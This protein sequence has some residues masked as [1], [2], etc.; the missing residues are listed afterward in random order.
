MTGWDTFF[1]VMALLDVVFVGAL[2]FVGLKMLDSVK[3]GQ[4][5]AQ[6]AID[7]AKALAELGKA[8]ANHAKEDGQLVVGRVKGVAGKVKERLE[9]TR[10][11]VGE[12]K[13]AAQET[14]TQ[15]QAQRADLS[16]KVRVIGDLALRAGRVKA[17]AEAA[18]DA[19]R[20]A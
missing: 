5:Q 9:T 18:R 6:P 16:R 1:V 12:L 4:K 3:R 8:L 10:R 19:S 17:A 14:S 15:L 13:P 20:T 2:A 11:V 7:E